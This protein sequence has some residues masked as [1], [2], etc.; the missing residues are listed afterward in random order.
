MATITLTANIHTDQPCPEAQATPPQI[1]LK[2]PDAQVGSFLGF[3]RC[4]AGHLDE[5][6]AFITA[7]ITCATN[8]DG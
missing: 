8:P 3:I 1:T 2:I 7:V 6:V 5:L 4:M